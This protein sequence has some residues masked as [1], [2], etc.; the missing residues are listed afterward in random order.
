MMTQF[1]LKI[2]KLTKKMA[3]RIAQFGTYHEIKTI[4][5][6]EEE[7]QKFESGRYMG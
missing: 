4:V 6:G 2:R 5:T 3:Y 7:A 1:S